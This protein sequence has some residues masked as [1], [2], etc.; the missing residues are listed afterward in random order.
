MPDEE[1]SEVEPTYIARLALAFFGT[2]A[3]EASS[4]SVPTPEE[5]YDGVVAW[6]DKDQR[7]RDLKA[8][9]SADNVMHPDMFSMAGK[10]SDNQDVPPPHRHVHVARFERPISMRVTIASRFQPQERGDGAIPAEDYFVGWDGVELLVMWAAKGVPADTGFFGGFAVLD[11]LT[12][13][14]RANGVPL[15]VEPCGPYCDYPFAHRDL[16]VSEAP[17]AVDVTVTD[18]DRRSVTLI[19]PSEEDPVVLARKL[20]KRLAFSARAFARMR[21]FG[22]SA[23]Q[24]EGDARREL[25]ELLQLQ[26]KVARTAS[27]GW[28]ESAAERWSNRGTVREMA[29]LTAALWLR[30]ANIE[31][32]RRRW[33]GAR[34]AFDTSGRFGEDKIFGIEYPEETKSVESIDVE[35]LRAAVGGMSQRADARTVTTATVAGAI[36]GGAVAGIIALVAALASASGAA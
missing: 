1:S 7:V 6:L 8:V 34:Y 27:L 23:T 9:A 19:C 10:S 11:L 4:G 5:L 22:A 33:S 18:R 17:T 3:H 26:Y 29:R 31:D 28:R 2:P 15:I 21:S 12:E 16:F 13:A 25:A 30:L 32:N 14:L 36:A 35:D 20:T 24:N